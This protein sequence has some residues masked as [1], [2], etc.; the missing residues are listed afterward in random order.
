MNRPQGRIHLWRGQKVRLCRPPHIHR[1]G[2]GRERGG[3]N[4]GE[5]PRRRSGPAAEAGAIAPVAWKARRL[6]RQQPEEFARP[7]A[8]AQGLSPNLVG[9]LT[10]CF[11]GLRRGRSW[12]RLTAS[13][14]ARALAGGPEPA[15]R[16]PP[17]AFVRGF[18]C[19]FG[20]STTEGQRGISASPAGGNAGARPGARP[21]F[22]CPGLRK[23]GMDRPARFSRRALRRSSADPRRWPP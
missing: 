18:Q 21:G 10:W 1:L 7:M 2:E 22:R 15:G 17:Q 16:S 20:K 11:R 23:D 13:T 5:D 8:G 12:P 4:T 3:R 6:F 14:A 9:W 19:P